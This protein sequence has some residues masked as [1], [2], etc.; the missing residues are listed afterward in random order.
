MEVLTQSTVFGRT[1]IFVR[2][3]LGGVSV[4]VLRHFGHCFAVTRARMGL[5]RIK[6]HVFRTISH[7]LLHV[8]EKGIEIAH[9]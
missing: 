6:V 7:L 3:K 5:F 8:V 4:D 9:G 1:M 2:F